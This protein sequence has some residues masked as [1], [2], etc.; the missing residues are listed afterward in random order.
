MTDG[1]GGAFQ[2]GAEEIV[3]SFRARAAYVGYRAFGS[4]DGAV[5]VDPAV[6]HELRSAAEFVT[7]ERRVT[8]GLLYGRGWADDQGAYLVVD[9]YLEAG[10]GENRGDRISADGTDDFTLSQADL[11]LLRE[12]AVR[13]YSA[14]L[15]VGWWRT[16]PALGDFGP[17]DF[18]TQ[19][20]LVG[21][22]GVGLL[23]YGSGVHWG[24]AYLGPDGLAPDSAGTLVAA[25]DTAEPPPAPGR[26]PDLAAAPV[27]VL[28][29]DPGLDPDLQAEPAGPAPPEPE[30]VDLAAG[31]SLLEDP[32]PH[33]VPPAAVLAPETMVSPDV[34]QETYAPPR[35]RRRGSQQRRTR[36]Q[37]ASA[38]GTT[39]PRVASA[40]S[41]TRQRVVSAAGRTRQRVRV[42]LRTR[43]WAG[44]P[45]S[46][47]SPPAETPVDVQIVVGLMIAVVIA[48]AIII[49]V[50]VHSVIVAV[51]IGGLGLLA[52]FSTVWMS[53]R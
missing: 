47:G 44:R 6:A 4:S 14:S 43:P 15:E 18:E 23:V 37:A 12:D 45:A 16:L 46:P 19:A 22:D 35:T 24:T 9:G 2:P 27:P 1:A 51:V 41:Q 33:P 53:H 11:R 36:P 7:Q 34:A 31:E 13:M 5:L 50:L 30:L 26:G 28:D 38:A 49:G 42:P 29:V 32:P 40:A 17:G 10:P 20:E 48:A 21:P 8:G 52:L 3:V 39:R 25:S